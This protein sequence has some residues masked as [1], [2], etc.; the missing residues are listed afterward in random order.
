MNKLAVYLTKEI[1]SLL[2]DPKK[3]SSTVF[4]EQIYEQ[5]YVEGLKMARKLLR[6]QLGLAVVDDLN[7]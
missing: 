6:I 1:D 5:G 7:D 3:T 2:K 4:T